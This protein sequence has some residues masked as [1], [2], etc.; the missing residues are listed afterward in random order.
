MIGRLA[1][2]VEGQ[3]WV[4]RV[5][6][7]DIQIGPDA[8]RD[9]VPLIDCGFVESVEDRLRSGGRGIDHA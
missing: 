5:P 6:V 3:V 4:R 9:H 7:V 8:W 2:G 1:S